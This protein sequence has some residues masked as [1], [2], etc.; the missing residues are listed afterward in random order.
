MKFVNVAGM[1]AS[2]LERPD[3]LRTLVSEMDAGTRRQ[4]Q[5]FCA[6]RSN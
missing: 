3:D 4:A 2:F 6:K 5:S 1:A